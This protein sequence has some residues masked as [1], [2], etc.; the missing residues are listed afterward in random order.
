MY[1][2]SVYIIVQY[3]SYSDIQLILVLWIHISI[4]HLQRIE[5]TLDLQSISQLH[6]E[7]STD[8]P[9]EYVQ[10]QYWGPELY[11][12]IEVNL[13]P[14]FMELVAMSTQMPGQWFFARKFS[15]KSDTWKNYNRFFQTSSVLSTCISIFKL[16]LN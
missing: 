5:M 8:F 16:K 1:W 12:N 6:N 11:L 9:L 14:H 7:N 10:S 3:N 4:M 2:C 15:S 13:W